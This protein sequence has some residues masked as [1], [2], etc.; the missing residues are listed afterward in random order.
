MA[1]FD[2]LIDDVASQF[3]LGSNSGPLVREILSMVTGTPGGVGGFLNTMKAS[4]LSS[5]VASWMGHANAAPLAAAQV[6]RALGSSALSGV[7]SRLGLAP[8]LV[9]TAVGYALPK[10]IGLLT[11]GGVIPT[12]LPAEV[13]N[14]V[15]AAPV[16]R[17]AAP[18]GRVADA[19]YQTV[20]RVTTPFVAPAQVAP[21]RIDVYHAPEAHDEPAMTG[22]LWPLLGALA[23]LGLGLLFWPTGNRTVAPPVVQAPAV[24][25]AP[26]APA[27]LPPRLEIA[28]DNGVARISGVVHDEATKN[29]ILNALRSVFGADKVQGDIAV[30]LN[31]AA[32]PWLVNFRNGIEALKTPG[33]Q[34]VFDGDSVNL[35]GLV[36]EDE[37]NRITSSMRSVLGGSLVFGA[38]ADRVADMVS[39]ANNRAA[40]A[41]ASLKSGFSPGDL[42]GALNQSVVNFA[43]GSADIPAAMSGF[44]QTAASNL[45]QLPQGT[46]IEIAGYTDNTGD[47][48]ANVA[49]SQK[50]AEAVRDALIKAGVNPDML[51]AKGYGS[52]NPIASN[53]L[54]EG[55]FSNRRI[56]YRVV[57]TP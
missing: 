42:T 21:R 38:L 26:P 44:F 9:S 10:V 27:L 11:P 24:A 48:Q 53:D 2:T 49:L 39:S 52:A 40:T 3:G 50:R 7:A 54:A 35:G 36:G 46:V 55:R 13:T 20:R 41:L 28:N 15:S 57:K 17:A 25:P 45:K 30:D 4:G 29:D 16:T 43:S 33:V 31:R 32:A 56:E 6:D 14:F 1:I 47:P 37:L 34:A 5:E 23:I 51:V 18:V 19:A 8:T 22:W 12:S